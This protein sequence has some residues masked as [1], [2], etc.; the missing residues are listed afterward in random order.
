MNNQIQM[1]ICIILLLDNM[2][3]IYYINMILLMNNKKKNVLNKIKKYLNNILKK[4]Y[5]ESNYRIKHKKKN[6]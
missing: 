3:D 4:T 6:N 2:Q 1:Y 5:K